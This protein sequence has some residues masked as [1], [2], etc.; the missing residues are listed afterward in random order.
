MRYDKNGLGVMEITLVSFYWPSL[1]EVFQTS[2]DE[3]PELVVY[4][5]RRV[6]DAYN[7]GTIKREV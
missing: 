1:Y 5:C 4:D 2:L 7:A 6:I 3:R